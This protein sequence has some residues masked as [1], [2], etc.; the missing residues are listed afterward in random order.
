[1]E[2]CV[3]VLCEGL[4]DLTLCSKSIDEESEWLKAKSS[5]KCMSG[6]AF[7]SLNF[8]SSL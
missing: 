4:E 1:M 7:K 6:L 3:A 8:V 5:T 2:N